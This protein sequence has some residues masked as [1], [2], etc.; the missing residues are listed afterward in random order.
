MFAYII[1]GIIPDSIYELKNLRILR[2]DNN[3]LE[4]LINVKVLLLENLKLLDL[5]RNQLSG[6]K[7]NK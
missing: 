3:K 5:N 6:I 4:G 2:L 7:I 1:L